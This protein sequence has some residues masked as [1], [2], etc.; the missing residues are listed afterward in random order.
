[1]L[2]SVSMP[3]GLYAGSLA[4]FCATIMAEHSIEP[5]S[6]PDH[7]DLTKNHEV[8]HHAINAHT[9]SETTDCYVGSI[10]TCNIG[11]AAA[12]ANAVPP[13]SKISV[14]F[15]PVLIQI[16]DFSADP[17]HISPSEQVFA[18]LYSPPIFLKN[19]SFL[20]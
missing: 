6:G 14:G 9:H 11:E 20:N 16:L 1:M 5:M 8:K 12:K 15:T 17:E 19:S 2:L 18:S 10:C 3:A 4:D 13:L 7:C